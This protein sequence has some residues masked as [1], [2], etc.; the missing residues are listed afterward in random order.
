M[1]LDGAEGGAPAPVGAEGGAPPPPPPPSSR[2]KRARKASYNEKEIAQQQLKR[3]LEE[4][5]QAAKA[6]RPKKEA[7]P[8]YE[9]DKILDKDKRGKHVYYRVRW[10][11]YTEDD[12][13]WEPAEVRRL[14]FHNSR[15]HPPSIQL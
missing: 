12:D 1:T 2:P 6:K 8:E 15:H 13:T 14:R 5:E 3:A 7:P 10:K 9:V 11:G 4:A